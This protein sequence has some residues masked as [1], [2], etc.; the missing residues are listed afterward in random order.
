MTNVF[1]GEPPADI[2]AWII[3]HATPTGHADTWYKYAG[4][5]EWRTVSISGAIEGD[6]VEGAPTSQIPDIINVIALEIGTDITSIG[7]FAF[8]FCENLTSVTIPDSVTSIGSNAFSGCISLTSITIPNN[9][10]SIG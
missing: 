6:V 9:V 3:E 10:T 2:K 4:D 7:D 8:A 1:L 5:T